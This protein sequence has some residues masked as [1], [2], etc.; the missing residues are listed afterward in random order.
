MGLLC[1]SQRKY[2][3][4]SCEL[5]Y[6][7]TVNSELS[8]DLLSENKALAR[9]LIA[10]EQ[11]LAASEQT[12]QELS[13][14]LADSQEELSVHE[15]R[16]SNKEAVISALEAQLRLA[17][18]GNSAVCQELTKVTDDYNKLMLEAEHEK[19]ALKH[20]Q[21]RLENQIPPL[22][23]KLGEL[24]SLCESLTRELAL[25]EQ[26][27]RSHQKQ[28]QSHYYSLQQENEDLRQCIN[29]PFT[30]SRELLS[31]KEES[32][33]PNSLRPDRDLVSNINARMKNLQDKLITRFK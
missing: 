20:Q 31:P 4:L 23:A 14:Q 32:K 5:Q 24:N 3:E 28:S 7:K 8:Q 10:S 18:Q 25:S 2:N 30:H 15:R 16:V 19:E 26:L 13:T 27:L 33:R 9:Q 29:S 21:Y 12:V 11:Q 6:E 1:A 22:E 17:E